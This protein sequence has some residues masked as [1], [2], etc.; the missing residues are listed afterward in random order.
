MF[1]AV[2]LLDI[3]K[4]AKLMKKLHLIAFLLFTLVSCSSS[5]T[6]TTSQVQTENIMDKRWN[7]THMNNEK[8]DFKTSLSIANSNFNGKAACNNYSGTIANYTN[9]NI[10]FKAI[11]STRMAC[12]KLSKEQTYFQALEKVTQYK[13]TNNILALLNKDKETVLVFTREDR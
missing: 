8:V 5:K 7:L 1:L 9:T 12:P 3:V 4:T 13:Q 6:N 11:I 2:F 10:H